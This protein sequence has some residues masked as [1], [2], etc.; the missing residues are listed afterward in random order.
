MYD[1]AIQSLRPEI[2][3]PLMHCTSLVTMK[4]LSIYTSSIRSSGVLLKM[5]GHSCKF[6]I[7]HI[8]T[9]YLSIRFRN[10]VQSCV[11]NLLLLFQ[12]IIIHSLH[13]SWLYKKSF[14]HLIYW[15]I[16]CISPI[17]TNNW[18][19]EYRCNLQMTANYIICLSYVLPLPA[20]DNRTSQTIE[21][22][23]L[24]TAMN[25]LYRL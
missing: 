10:C 6:P 24:L 13:H 12:Y 1:N 20:D 16:E 3:S 9:N 18:R 17:F 8:S 25:S 14:R 7:N 15:C 4:A 2:C 22:G 23:L 21:F 11:N 5:I 19:T